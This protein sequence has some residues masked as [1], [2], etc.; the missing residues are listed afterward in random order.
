MDLLRSFF[1]WLE[2][3]WLELEVT[4]DSGIRVG[5]SLLIA[6]GLGLFVGF[7]YRTC[8]T[9]V[10]GKNSF[11]RLFP[12]LVLVTTAM[13]YVVKSSL[14]L[15][16]GL[17]GALS[18]VRFRAAIKEPEELIYLF[19]CIAI[20]VGIGAGQLVPAVA[21]VFVSSLF[22][23]GRRF[24][25]GE[26]RHESFLVTV[27]GDSAKYFEGSKNTVVDTVNHLVSHYTLQRYEVDGER[28]CIRFVVPDAPPAETVRL[29]SALRAELPEC[30]I[31]Y[32][33]LE[34][35]F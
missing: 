33:N 2:F 3:G 8:S 24:L 32:V 16:L 9:S 20:G 34:H 18:I 27:T 19:M 23:L 31:A 28:G 12:L 22:V 4:I 13:I 15:S 10:S 7:L 5:A 6:G 26:E 29:I 17:V 30:H 1:G 25:S 35:S 21:L 11:S 14:A